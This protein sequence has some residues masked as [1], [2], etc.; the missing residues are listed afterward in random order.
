MRLTIALLLPLMVLRAALP[1][2][3]MPVADQGGFRIVLCSDG[4]L[5]PAMAGDAAADPHPDSGSPADC[6]FA[7][8]AMAALVTHQAAD[9]V[10]SRAGFR[11]IVA[12]AD[13]NPPATGPPRTATARAPPAL[14]TS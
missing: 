7:H 4:L 5:L 12:F 14:L 11:F 10:A 9:T 1:S 6:V 13:N 8:C 2:G 3:F